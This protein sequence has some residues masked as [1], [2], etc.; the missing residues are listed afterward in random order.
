MMGL[1]MSHLWSIRAVPQGQ[2]APGSIEGCHFWPPSTTC[3]SRCCS[4]DLRNLHTL[5]LRFQ[6][7]CPVLLSRRS[8]PRLAGRISDI[9]H[10]H[11]TPCLHV[12][13]LDAANLQLQQ[14]LLKLY[15]WCCGTC[16]VS[17]TLT[18]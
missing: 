3:L 18:S 7:S 6:R 11:H 8:M 5:H 2:M 17:Y 14:A 10:Q 16:H 9:W 15:C 1:V 12:L 4:P 13:T